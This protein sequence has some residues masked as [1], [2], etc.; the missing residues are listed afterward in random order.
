MLPLCVRVVLRT[1]PLLCTGDFGRAAF[2]E[3]PFCSSPLALPS[4]FRRFFVILSS[5]RSLIFLLLFRSFKYGIAE[6]VDFRKCRIRARESAHIY[7]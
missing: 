3:V 4:F 7:P 1:M 6:N 2:R 5:F